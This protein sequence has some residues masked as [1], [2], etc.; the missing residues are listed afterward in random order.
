MVILLLLKLPTQLK[1]HPKS[2]NAFSFKPKIDDQRNYHHHAQGHKIAERPLQFGHIF[3][4]HSVNTRNKS[5]GQK[6]SRKDGQQFHYII[7]LL[8]VDRKIGIQ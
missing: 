8:C 3:K 6:E 1:K 7:A 5:Q 4:V 2:K